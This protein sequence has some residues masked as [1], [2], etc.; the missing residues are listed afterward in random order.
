MKVGGVKKVVFT[1]TLAHTK[2]LIEHKKIKTQGGG[3]GGRGP[4]GAV[5]II[6]IIMH[7]QKANE[8][9]LMRVARP[10]RPLPA[11]W[12]PTPA[13]PIWTGV[14]VGVNSRERE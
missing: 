9:S 6:I 2:S 13:R 11:C 8:R 14:A 5:I 10:E 1:V 4:R 12:R 7:L 3:H